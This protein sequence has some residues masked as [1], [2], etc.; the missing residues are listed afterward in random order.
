MR[1]V[2][3]HPVGRFLL[4]EVG[5]LIIAAVINAVMQFGY[6]SSLF[7]VSIV[8]LILGSG[9][10]AGRGNARTL[11]RR[12][13]MMESLQTRKMRRQIITE[14]TLIGGVPF[15]LAIVLALLRI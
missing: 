3:Q 2:W 4:I 12:Y 8:I 9:D 13:V 14:L 15:L 5:I 6:S 11:G 7:I 1:A 10:L